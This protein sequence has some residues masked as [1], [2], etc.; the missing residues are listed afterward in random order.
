MAKR[1][2][3]KQLEKIRANL[4][5][6]ATYVRDTQAWVKDQRRI[7]GVYFAWDHGSQI[8]FTASKAEVKRLRAILRINQ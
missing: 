3:E 4:K 6:E 5:I 1:L 2:S 7:H 8:Q